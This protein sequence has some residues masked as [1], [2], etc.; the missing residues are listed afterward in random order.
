MI[1][2]KSIVISI[3][4]LQLYAHHGVA[5]QERVVG[6]TFEVSLSVQYPAAGACSDD[7]LDGTLNYATAIDVIKR[8]MAVPSRLLEHVAARIASSITSQFPQITNGSVT[9]TKLVPP[10]GVE[11]KG[12][13]VTVNW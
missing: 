9:V 5:E 8:E 3:D 1:D 4:R 13:S 7:N 6:N 10:C 11:V 12:V 2:I